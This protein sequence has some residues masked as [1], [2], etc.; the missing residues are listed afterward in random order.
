MVICPPQRGNKRRE[1]P[2][3]GCEIGYLVWSQP[4]EVRKDLMIA[5]RIL[6]GAILVVASLTTSAMA[7]VVVSSKIDTEGGVLGNIIQQVLNA[8]GIETTDRIQLG[9]SE[10]RRVGKECRSTWAP[11]RHVEQENQSTRHGY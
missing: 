9:R 10:E 3:S 2:S 5:M 7:D 4:S 8:N 6:T 1:L 11:N